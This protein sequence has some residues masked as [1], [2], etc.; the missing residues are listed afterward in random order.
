MPASERS[1]LWRHRG[2]LYLWA[3][4]AVSAFGSRITRTA[5]PI[6]AVTTL[7]APEEIVGVLVAVNSAPS[8]IFA[9][10]AGG[11]VDR[12]RKRRLM[13][14]ADLVRAGIIASLTIA[15]AAGV[16]AMPHVVVVGAVVGAASALFQIADAAYLPSLVAP[17][18]LAEGNAKLATTDALAEVCGPASAGVLFAVL[19]APLAVVINAATY[20][21]SAVMLGRIRNVNEAPPAATEPPHVGRDLAIGLRAVFGHP[22]V[23][24]TVIASGFALIAGGFFATLYTLYCFRV[25][26]LD[27]ATFGVIIA[28]G[29]VGAVI[30]AQ[31]ARPLAR[32]IGLGRA[33]VLS[34][35]FSL[36]GALFI[37]LA[38]GPEVFK[39]GCLVAHQLLS[40]GLW[41]V[42]AI[43]TATLRQTVLPKAVLGRANAATFVVTVGVMPI[44][45]LVAGEL[46]SLTSIRIAVWVGVSIGLFATPFL[47]PLWRLRELPAS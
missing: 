14:R 37:P 5:L 32:A 46:A 40:D 26:D 25:L 23:R 10:V 19:G 45:A 24:P 38:R 7:G 44:A 28:M 43:H 31:L 4:Q 29:G 9:L 27:K 12:G 13:I 6:I 16:L 3:A 39:I 1:D 15:W 20:L 11:Y 36:A 42:F 30:G 17:H 21:W 47:L 35:M 34:A 41:I 2:F 22:L 33:I 18:Q 8:V